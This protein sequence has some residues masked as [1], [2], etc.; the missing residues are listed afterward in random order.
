MLLSSR[1]VMAPAAGEIGNDKGSESSKSTG[2][3]LM[4]KNSAVDG[5]VLAA[6]AAAE[7]VGERT[8]CGVTTC[9]GIAVGRIFGGRPRFFGIRSGTGVVGAGVTGVI[10][11][12]VATGVA[13]GEV[14]MGEGEGAADGG[15]GSV[16]LIVDGPGFD[17]LACPS[18][19]AP[20]ETCLDDKPEDFLGLFLSLIFGVAIGAGEGESSPPGVDGSPCP[21]ATL[22]L[23][24]ILMI[25]VAG[26]AGAEGVRPPRDSLSLIG[27]M[28][29]GVRREGEERGY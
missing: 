23:P 21:F 22:F 25:G 18:S 15:L 10:V 20:T 16:N 5:G 9:G 13:A 28:A 12:G 27:G 6:E 24:L 2:S 8:A 3:A 4:L 29:V 17:P 7:V 26:V 14:T 1:G 11:S 19:S